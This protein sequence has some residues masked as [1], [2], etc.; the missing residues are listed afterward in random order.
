MEKDLAF[1][2][3]N[4]DSIVRSSPA[5]STNS[6]FCLQI[7]MTR[8]NITV[9]SMNWCCQWMAL[10]TN[11][12]MQ[13]LEKTGC[14]SSLQVTHLFLLFMW[15]ASQ[16]LGKLLF[17]TEFLDSGSGTPTKKA[18]QAQLTGDIWIQ[19]DASYLYPVVGCASRRPSTDEVQQS[20]H[21]SVTVHGA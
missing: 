8:D 11:L 4:R 18:F 20:Q 17:K 16:S 19:T 10:G 5:I 12:E 14:I 13:N 6:L 3:R 21:R 9:K 7:L 1:L 15:L 2:I